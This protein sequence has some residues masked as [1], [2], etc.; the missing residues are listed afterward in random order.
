MSN[1]QK[2]IYGII[3]FC[4][5]NIMLVLL[6]LGVSALSSSPKHQMSFED[7]LVRIQNKEIKN[8]VIKK[9]F[10]ELN[11]LSNN[12]FQTTELTENQREELFKTVTNIN[13]KSTDTIRMAEEPI[14][15]DLSENMFRIML[16]L[17]FISPPIIVV[18][19]LI[20]IKKMDNKKSI[21]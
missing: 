12:E 15:S 8:V 20:I 13:A 18:L 17:F 3:G 2:F 21:S 10:A 19:L 6:F 4:V 11:N 9:D 1:N 5:G 14:K 7:A 16:L